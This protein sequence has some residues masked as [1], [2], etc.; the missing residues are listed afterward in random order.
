MYRCTRGF[1]NIYSQLQSK[2]LR[3]FAYHSSFDK[4]V[5]TFVVIMKCFV[6]IKGLMTAL[7]KRAKEN[8][9]YI[10]WGECSANCI[11]G[12][13][14]IHQFETQAVHFMWYFH[15]D[16]SFFSHAS[17]MQL[18]DGTWRHP[19]RTF[20]ILSLQEEEEEGSARRGWGRG[21][22]K[23]AKKALAGCR[24]VPSRSCIVEAWQKKLLSWWKYL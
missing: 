24:A 20:L 1:L 15:Q 2:P 14:W 8:L 19:A 6:H 5:I 21:C 17:K 9:L 3:W 12:S 10:Q 23:R 4:F 13:M 18:L 7:Q 22:K 16:N 11:A